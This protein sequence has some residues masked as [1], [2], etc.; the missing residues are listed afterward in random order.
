MNR[1]KLNFLCILLVTYF[2]LQELYAL[3]YTVVSTYFSSFC[4][5]ANVWW[6]FW[7][8]VDNWSFKRFKALSAKVSPSNWW[9]RLC[10]L[11]MEMTKYIQHYE[12][13]LLVRNF[14]LWCYLHHSRKEQQFF[15]KGFISIDLVFPAVLRNTV[16]RIRLIEIPKM[17]E[18]LFSEYVK[19]CCFFSNYR[20]P[21]ETKVHLRQ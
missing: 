6:S 8:I 1:N 12:V 5:Y 15:T 4:T 21:L 13:K 14:C 16:T 19:K 2:V 3:C 18:L 11:H 10:I 7:G 20:S 17:I 9:C